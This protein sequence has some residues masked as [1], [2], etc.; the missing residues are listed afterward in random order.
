MFNYLPDGDSAERL[1]RQ[2]MNNHEEEILCGIDG[3][4]DEHVKVS[5]FNRWVARAIRSHVQPLKEAVR[6]QNDT[7]SKHIH[8]E[9]M[10]LAKIQGGI[11]VLIWIGPAS[12]AIMLYILYIMHKAGLM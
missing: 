9:E 5:Q 6:E 12:S 7:L 1:K 10:M 4:E 2:A 3:D 8:D 11:K